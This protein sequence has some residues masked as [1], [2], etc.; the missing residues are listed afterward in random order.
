MAGH[1]EPLVINW[2]FIRISEKPGQ[3]NREE[4]TNSLR[5]QRKNISSQYIFWKIRYFRFYW[6]HKLGHTPVLLEKMTRLEH[7]HSQKGI[8]Y[9]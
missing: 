1:L 5:H 7:F 4:D 9:G 8:N 2:H 6:P 3:G